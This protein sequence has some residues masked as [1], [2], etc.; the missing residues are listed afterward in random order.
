MYLS[1]YSNC[2]EKSYDVIC[3]NTSHPIIPHITLT[4]PCPTPIPHTQYTPIQPISHNIPITE[5]LPK[6]LQPWLKG[7]TP[8]PTPSIT[9]DN[10]TIWFVN[11]DPDQWLGLAERFK[12]E[13]SFVQFQQELTKLWSCQ[14]SV[15]R[16]ASIDRGEQTDDERLWPYALLCDLPWFPFTSIHNPLFPLY[17]TQ[18]LTTHTQINHLIIVTYTWEIKPARLRQRFPLKS[19]HNIQKIYSP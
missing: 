1:D 9:I 17:P 8:T 15:L 16:T 3:P 11:S 10:L 5:H 12:N 6:W 7:V 2:H 13:G 18:R 4:H 14:V 19:H